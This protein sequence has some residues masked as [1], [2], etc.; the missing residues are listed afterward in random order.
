MEC[1]MIQVS[2]G[3]KGETYRKLVPQPVP[4]S[5]P[6]CWE[7]VVYSFGRCVFH[8]FVFGV[9]MVILFP[10]RFCRPEDARFVGGTPTL[11]IFSN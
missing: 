10:V 2:Q 4:T 3:R 7:L 1:F 8:D 5:S 11:V 9:N 6:S